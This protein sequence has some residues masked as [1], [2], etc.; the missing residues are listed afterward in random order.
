L[1]KY[2]KRVCLKSLIVLSVLG[3]SPFFPGSMT[4]VKAMDYPEIAGNLIPGMLTFYD[5]NHENGV[6]E[7]QIS[8]RPVRSEDAIES[9]MIYFLDDQNRKIELIAEEEK[10]D[11]APIAYGY[12]LKRGTTYPKEATQIGVFVRYKEGVAKEGARIPLG[13]KF[14][15]SVL[16]R[17]YDKDPEQGKIKGRVEWQTPSGEQGV[18]SYVISFVDKDGESLGVFEEVPVK[19]PKTS[20]WITTDVIPEHTVNLKVQAKTAAGVLIPLRNELERASFSDDISGESL[21]AVPVDKQLKAPG[22]VHFSGRYDNDK[23]L[24]GSMSIGGLSFDSRV[25]KY[26][27]YFLDVQGNKIGKIVEVPAGSIIQNEID[28][29]ISGMPY[30]DEAVGIGAFGVSSQGESEKGAKEWIWKGKILPDKLEL[31]SMEGT[32]LKLQWELPKGNS[33]TVSY[34]VDS[35]GYK[36]ESKV[37]QKIGEIKKQAE[38]VYTLVV[39]VVPSAEYKLSHVEVYAVNAWGERSQQSTLLSIKD[40]KLDANLQRFSENIESR[41]I[42]PKA[43]SNPTLESTIQVFVDGEKVSFD[44]RPF[45]EEGSTLV[46]FRPIFEKLGLQ[47]QWDEV[48]RS[49]VGTKGNQEIKLTI[50]KNEVEVGGHTALLSVAPRIVQ[51]V[52]VVPLR[53]VGEA[54]GRKVIWD[55]NLRAVYIIDPQTEGKLYF[56]NGKV[57]Y[58][59]QL[60]DGKMHG[61]GKLYHEN[62]TLWYD[63]EFQNDEVQ[64]QGTFVQSGLVDGRNMSGYYI[65]G[66]LVHGVPNGQGRGYTP[67]GKLVYEGEFKGG[68]FHGQGKY[69]VNGELV[70]EGGFAHNQYEGY[71][72]LYNKEYVEYEGEF[73][74]NEWHGKGKLYDTISHLLAYDGEFRDG[75][76]Q[77]QGIEYP[78]RNSV[79]KGAFNNGYREGMGIDYLGGVVE[80]EGEFHGNVREGKGKLYYNDNSMYEGEFSKQYPNG[81]GKLT[82]KDGHLIYEGEFVGGKPVGQK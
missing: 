62:G 44:Q 17:F 72:K 31:I 4:Q 38:G 78:W 5:S 69:F 42:A 46:Q 54:T 82:D 60:V 34:E 41:T 11:F 39:N 52:T 61:K 79:Y 29:F 19:S 14:T 56:D 47:I 37:N 1:N 22:N 25:E 36:N 35:V 33:P 77:G 55:D 20:S 21:V 2:L 15:I 40:L 53:F 63:A 30:P 9:Y 23:T 76:R 26:Q 32:K 57:R 6:I 58:E 50:G 65:S 48:N 43:N 80:Y 3:G 24:W 68:K 7:G 73:K 64:G 75:I 66:N 81:K 70:Y 67:S 71:G 74:Q 10:G 8:W 45:I 28:L 49:I 16:P 12:E 51:D 13:D 18:A 59:G 27:V